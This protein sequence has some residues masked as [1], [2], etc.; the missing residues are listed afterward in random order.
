MEKIN[1]RIKILVYIFIAAWIILLVR[2]YAISI[3]NH[4]YYNLLA[5]KNIIKNVIKAP[6]RGI[7]KD[8]NG[9][10]VAINK[11]GFSISLDPYLK[12]AALEK[13]VDSIT[14][15][16]KDLSKDTLIKNYMK[17]KSPYNHDPIQVVPFV[18]YD[19][20]QKYYTYL[21]QNKEIVIE[22]TSKRY[23]P[24]KSSGSHV[25]GYIGA[26][27]ERDISENIVSKYTGIVGRTG[28]EKE[29]NSFLQGEIGEKIVVVDAHN[30]VIR[31]ES[32]KD[33]VSQKDLTITLD[34]RLQEVANKAFERNQKNG[35]LIVMD[36][37]NGEILAAGSYPE[38]DLNDFVGGIS[39]T[40]WN[41][42]QQDLANPLLNKLVNSVYAPGSVV[43]MGVAL[44][45]LEYAGINELTQIDTPGFIELGGRKFRDWKPQG[46]GKTDVIK[47]IRESVDVYF[48]RLSQ[49]A[50]MSNIA[51]VLSQMGFGKKTGVDLPNEFVG[52]LPSPE[53]K[54]N[55]GLVWY[56]GDTVVTSI[57]QGSFLVTPMQIARY[58]A[59]MASSSLIT[60]HF[61][62]SD[63]DIFVKKDVLNS[64]QKSKLKFIQE[65]MHQACSAQSGT[66]RRAVL[67]VKVSIACKTGTAQVVSIPQNI[68]VRIKESD[69]PY[70]HRSHAWITGYVPYKNPKYAI[71]V[72]IEHGE[73]GGN[74]GP[75]M[76][77]VANALKKYGYI[78]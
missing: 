6:F 73:S 58:T 21:A 62:K 45:L 52:I 44:A 68:K 77:E 64:F 34:M 5:Q 23:Y 63:Q 9:T 41:I 18:D 31:T 15:F 14:Y 67:D 3:K 61:I 65:G 11:L 12:P 27:D 37:H 78:K 51:N 43:K 2:I 39:H 20:M 59:L 71:T 50:N 60:P 26:S 57:G 42:L 48:Y 29:Y 36:V 7:I 19:L 10:P 28:L 74:A 32:K 17:K 70:Y 40:K 4:D 72:F 16:F 24:F 53:W 69:L 38:Y 33:S 55:K 47:A 25:I 30:R 56:L 8:R 66:A 76:V 22:P 1:F 35:A 49:Q 13:Q 75:I 46:H 54:M